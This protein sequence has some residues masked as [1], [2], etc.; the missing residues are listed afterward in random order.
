MAEKPAGAAAD[1]RSDPSLAVGVARSGLW[2][3]GGQFAALIAALLATP[4]TIRLLGPVKYGLWSLLR[5]VLVYFQLADLGMATAST[6]FA[7]ERYAHDDAVGEGTVIWSALAVTVALTAAAAIVAS[8]VAP[9]L[10]TS[11]L[12]V[13]TGL[14]SSGVLALRLVC[15]AAVAYAATNVITTPQQ[16]R[17][18]FR[19][20]TLAMSGPAVSQVA[21]APVVLAAVAG[22]VVTMAA[23][24]ATAWIVAAGLNFRAAARLLPVLRRPRVTGAT[25]RPIVKY[26]G[27][28]AISGLA[29]IPL[30]TASWFLLAH[31]RSATAVAYYAA[32]SALGLLITVI[33]LAVF[34]PMLPALTRLAS[35]E[36]FDEH[37]R[38]YHQVLRGAFLLSTSAALVLAFLGHPFLALW[39]GPVYGVHSAGAFYVILVGLWF[40]TLAYVPY[41]QL[42]A[43]G[44]T[45]TLAVIHLAELIPYLLLAAVLT[46]DFGVVGAASASA[47]RLIVDSLAYFAI[48]R[49]R[50]KLPW[51]PT[52]YRGAASVIAFLCLGGVLFGLSAVTSSLA[53]RAAWS[54][55]TMAVFGTVMW[56]LVLTTS[57]RSSLATLVGGIVQRAGSAAT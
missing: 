48:V 56:R 23:V 10:V 34:Q 43:S 38:L 14:R 37:R 7:A 28:L 57:E 26:G 53:V 40:N 5:S 41:G 11:V 35:E 4:F 17:L 31:F 16:V 47:V 20:V 50:Y 33:P 27:A 21:A 2:A 18:R 19:S 42:L 22:G 12:H 13:P 51:V 9:F 44:R 30:S 1:E 52:P 45:S 55:I 54:V 36:R 3:G 46:S 32:A 15:V 6:R 24:M 8:L 25:L 39:A 29:D 49:H